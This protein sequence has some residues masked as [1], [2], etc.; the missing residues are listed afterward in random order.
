M[1]VKARLH[2]EHEKD[3]TQ[4]RADKRRLHNGKLALRMSASRPGDLL[5]GLTL[6]SARMATISSTALP[7]VALSSPPR[8]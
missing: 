4:D 2:A 6:M 1:R 5:R 8:V 7:K 3:V